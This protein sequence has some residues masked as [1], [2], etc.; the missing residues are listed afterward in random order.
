VSTY[1]RP[2]FVVGRIVNPLVARLGAKPALATRGRKTGE[3]RTVPVN[4]LEKDGTRY[5]VSTRGDAFWVRNLRADP[6]VE[7]R[8]R[9][10]AQRLRATLV[11]EAERPALIA[12]YLARW[13]SEAATYFEQLP[14]PADHP[15]YRLDPSGSAS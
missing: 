9:G 6:E 8:R 2:S 15:V 12:A 10:R 4:V 11:P 14:D 3:W 5:L 13:R 1:L 7:L